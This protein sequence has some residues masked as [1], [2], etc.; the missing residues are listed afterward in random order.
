MQKYY[1]AT[2]NRNWTG[3]ATDWKDAAKR[4]VKFWLQNDTPERLGE[5]CCI[6]ETGFDMENPDDRIGFVSVVLDELGVPYERD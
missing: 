4:A 1:V 2:K 3:L 5:I 6:S